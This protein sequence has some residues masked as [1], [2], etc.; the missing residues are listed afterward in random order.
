M[1]YNYLIHLDLDCETYGDEIQEYAFYQSLNW[2]R[3]SESLRLEYC[4][5]TI[6]DNED[7]ILSY[8]SLI[9][10]GVDDEI[11]DIYELR[12]I[13]TGFAKFLGGWIDEPISSFSEINIGDIGDFYSSIYG[14]IDVDWF[15][16]SEKRSDVEVNKFLEDLKTLYYDC[17]L[18]SLLHKEVRDWL[19]EY[20]TRT[21]PQKPLT[22]EQQQHIDVINE[23]ARAFYLFL[24]TESWENNNEPLPIRIVGTD[25]DPTVIFGRYCISEER[26]Y[27]MLPHY[28]NSELGIKTQILD[29]AF[30]GW[31]RLKEVNISSEVANFGVCAFG[32]CIKLENVQLNEN[33]SVLPQYTFKECLS[34]ERISIPLSVQ[35]I[36]V[37]AFENCKVLKDVELNY[38]TKLQI[39]DDGAFLNCSSLKNITLPKTL[40]EIGSNAFEASGIEKIT[41]PDSVGWIGEGAFS[42]CKELTEVEFPRNI[43]E[44]PASCFQEC[45]KLTTVNL[46]NINKIGD[47]AFSGCNQIKKLP[48]PAGTREIGHDVFL[49]CDNLSKISIPESLES[50]GHCQFAKDTVI[51]CKEGSYIHKVAIENGWNFDIEN[52]FC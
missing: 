9:L 22:C 29:F 12:E 43:N 36:G 49:G 41:I 50:I 16:E 46:Y 37:H 32:N 18:E 5:K 4:D 6:L 10:T 17:K 3:N 42:S 48:I 21:Y 44:L 20:I 51:Y 15:L 28:D 25:T 31:E 47:N 52:A 38:H 26:S 23:G 34:L 7:C 14:K 1:S 40:D 24:G 27:V 13:L 30:Y 19:M 11:Q 8:N 45:D 35:I 33:M 2:I 39:I